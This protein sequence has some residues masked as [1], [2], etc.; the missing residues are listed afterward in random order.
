MST[1]FTKGFLLQEFF[2]GDERVFS[3]GN[4]NQG[5][6]GRR[7]AELQQAFG[8][9]AAAAG[10]GHHGELAERVFRRLGQAQAAGIGYE[11]E[12]LAEVEASAIALVIAPGMSISTRRVWRADQAKKSAFCASA[13]SAR[14]R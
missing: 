8:R 9:H 13:A 14:A 7:A 3:I 12:P 2:E 10:P 6:R 5:E 1:G 11:R 4:H